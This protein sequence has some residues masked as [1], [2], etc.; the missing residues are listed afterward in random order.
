MAKCV[1]GEANKF[2]MPQK[3]RKG[4]RSMRVRLKK[5]FPHSVFRINILFNF[6]PQLP[7]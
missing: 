5:Y 7:L 4:G 1:R 6:A 2:I 3:I